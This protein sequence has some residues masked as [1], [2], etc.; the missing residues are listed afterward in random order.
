[1]LD[2][3]AHSCITV[4]AQGDYLYVA[5]IIYQAYYAEQFGCSGLILYTDPEDYHR[6]KKV[7][8]YPDSWWMPPTGVQRGNVFRFDGDPLTPGYPSIGK[9]NLVMY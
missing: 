3:W 8:A 5:I 1:M 2:I 6:D 7:P 4:G 9:L